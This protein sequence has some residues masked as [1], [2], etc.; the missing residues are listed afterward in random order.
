MQ[1]V[2]GRGGEV[3]AL[4]SHPPVADGSRPFLRK[5][6]HEHPT[7]SPLSSFFTPEPYF[8]PPVHGGLSAHIDAA[9]V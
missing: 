2:S 8:I 3:K 6:W 7:T 9:T 4:M 5:L 1:S